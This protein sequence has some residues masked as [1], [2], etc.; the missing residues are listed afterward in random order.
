MYR[1]NNMRRFV[2]YFQRTLKQKL[3]A[4]TMIAIGIVP[5]WLDGDATALVF[6]LFFAVPMLI[7]SKRWVA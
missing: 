5:V 6:V 2:R 4:L 7:S 1:R 3:Y